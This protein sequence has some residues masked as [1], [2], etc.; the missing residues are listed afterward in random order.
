[1]ECTLGVVFKGVRCTEGGHDRVT[2]ELL[3]RPAGALDFLGHRA[4]K[5]IEQNP[6]PLRILGTGECR[7]ADEVGEQHRRQ[8]P[9]LGWPLIR[10]RRTATR[11]E[12][13]VRRDLRSAAAAD[14][15]ARIVPQRRRRVSAA[16]PWTRRRS[17]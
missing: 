6:R 11:A 14:G 8:L 3:D 16:A 4:V 9:L 1:M 17:F 13:R 7:R 12:V 5:A 2:D 10:D 15:H